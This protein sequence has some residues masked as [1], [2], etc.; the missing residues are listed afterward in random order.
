MHDRTLPLVVDDP[1]FGYFGLGVI[2]QLLFVIAGT[3]L[4]TFAHDFHHQI[5]AVP[6][7]VV[8]GVEMI[9]MQKDNVGQT[10]LARSNPKAYPVGIDLAEL[11]LRDE[12]VQSEE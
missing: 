3:D 7:S 9:L 1:V 12:F 8:P 11:S 4:W 2:G 10:N 6:N 5:G